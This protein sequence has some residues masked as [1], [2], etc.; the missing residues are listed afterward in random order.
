VVHPT[1]EERQVRQ[2]NPAQ[3]IKGSARDEGQEGAT[4]KPGPKSQQPESSMIRALQE[5]GVIIWLL[6]VH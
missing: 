1:T 5:L 4:G 3:G 2:I 6:L